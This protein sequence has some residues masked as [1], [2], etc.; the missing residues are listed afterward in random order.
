MNK[1]EKFDSVMTPQNYLDTMIR[2]GVIAF[3]VFLSVQVFAPFA[4]I[5]LWAL[6]LSIMIYPIHQKL[7]KKMDGKQGRAA[8]LIVLGGCLLIGVPTIMLGFSFLGH[9]TELMAAFRNDSLSIV[10]PSSEVKEW[11]LV[12][13]KIYSVWAQAASDLPGFFSANSE[14]IVALFR[15]LFAVAGGV[16]GFVFL[17]VGALIISGIMMA[18]GE[19]GSAAMLRIANRV[20]GASRGARLQSI[21]VAT[22]RSV[23]TGVV[24]VAFVQAILLG[25]GFLLAGIPAAGIL[26]VISLL[27]GIMQ[28]PAALVAVPA[29]IY[30]WSA[31]GGSVAVNIGLSV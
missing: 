4:L 5:M 8:S 1:S 18:W 10:M 23:A 16:A 15:K 13:G 27:L 22:V 12:G 11:P 17:F 25:I 20:S 7:A 24:G 26:A 28:I 6:V 3:V 29:M 31:G 21:S 14:Q 9:V 30:I 19:E 2:L